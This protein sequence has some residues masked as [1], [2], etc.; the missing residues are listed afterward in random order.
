MADR[1]VAK[2][3]L[4]A[5]ATGKLSIDDLSL[6]VARLV[7]Q[8]D[9]VTNE[10]DEVRSTRDEAEAALETNDSEAFNVLRAVREWF[11]DVILFG[12]TTRTPREIVRKV[13]RALSAEGKGS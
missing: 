5:A 1:S 8:L 6:L 7:E 3:E 2:S 13:E 12:K 10:L 9:D 4:D 11:D